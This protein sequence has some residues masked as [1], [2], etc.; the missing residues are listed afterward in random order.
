VIRETGVVIALIVDLNYR[1]WRVEPEPAV[2]TGGK[3]DAGCEG[4]ER[5]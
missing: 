1:R 4:E 3:F 2:E 5:K